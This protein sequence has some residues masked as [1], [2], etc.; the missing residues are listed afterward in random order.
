[1]GLVKRNVVVLLSGAAITVLVGVPQVAAQDQNQN[2][3][4][5]TLLER[6]VIGAGAPKIA[7]DTPQAVT[8]VDQADLD[9]KAAT[10]TR[11]A[12]S[13]IPSVTVIGSDRVF[14][15]AFNIRGIGATDSS[16]DGS[17][18]IVTVD[19]A[20]KFNEQYRM[21]SFFS[22]PELYKRVEV[23][24]GPASATLYGSGA[25]GGV[26]NFTTKDA[27][28]FIKDGYNGAIR[29]KGQYESNGQGTLTSALLA[30]RI[31]ETF[32]V[33]ATGNFRRANNFE[34]ANGTVLDGS[35]FESWSGLLKGTARFGDN[36]EQVV[37]LSYQRWQSD[38]ND[39]PY[40][41]TGTMLPIIGFGNVDRKVTDDTV[42]LSYENPA[43]DNPWVDVNL[44]LSYSD[45]QNHQRNATGVGSPLFDDV[46]YGYRTFQLKG[47]NTVDTVLDGFENHFTF[48]GLLSR[49]DRIASKPAG[50]APSAFH[51]EGVESKLGLFVQNEA[52][53]DNR[54]TVIGGVRADIHNMEPSSNVAGASTISGVA[55]SPKIAALYAIT[56]NV[57]VF[58]SLAHTERFPTLDELFSTSA[59]RSTSMS[60]RP[61]TA[62]NFEVG[63]SASAYDVAGLENAVSVKTT[64]FYNDLS[65]LITTNATAAAA[66]SPYYINI[67]KARI[68]GVEIEGAYDSDL[69]FGRLAFSLT[70]GENSKTGAALANI[71]ASKTVL[72][73]GARNP[74]WGLEYGV[75]GTLTADP[76]RALAGINAASTSKAYQKVD[77]FASWK[78]QDGPLAGTEAQFT[79]EN[80]FNADFRDNLSV[81]RSKG[82]TFKLTLAKQFDY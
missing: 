13:G 65:D 21:G 18:I 10:T 60:L 59:T 5:V 62:N 49:Q 46:D 6:L 36:D 23:L 48:G 52:V 15:E 75:R 73:L 19:G 31:N 64:A 56:D 63:F 71:P 29:I 43:S 12:L 17:R 47:D 66:G 67:D 57:N 78:P 9:S 77:L 76:D 51:P 68:Y 28:E 54:I 25:I 32:D 45:T 39:Q 24:R 4:Y 42:V 41:Q 58:S 44:S 40:A 80:V 8:V 69:F 3:K 30:Q 14:G 74:E 35:A 50:Q 79:I 38:A 26:I 33:L 27:S 7:T 34:L 82:R 61:E 2:G 22:D 16:S 37:R 72:T 1:M 70:K 53:W 81:D 20:P 11:D 55:W